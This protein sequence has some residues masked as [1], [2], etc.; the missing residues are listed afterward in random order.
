VIG[1]PRYIPSDELIATSAGIP[2]IVEV[3]GDRFFLL[4]AEY[5]FNLNEQFELAMFLDVGDALFEDQNWGFETARVSAGIEARF[6]LPIFPVPLRLIY[7]VPVR[8]V[9]GD[10]TSNFQFSL[11]RSF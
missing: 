11:G 10:R 7:G 3:G 4:Q 6:H 5:V 1:D 8:S 2:V 9:R